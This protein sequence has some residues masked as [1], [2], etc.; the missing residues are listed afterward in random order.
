[1][2]VRKLTGIVSIIFA[3][4]LCASPAAGAF[5]SEGA[6]CCIQPGDINHD[7]R[8]NVSDLTYLVDFMF[9][10]GPEIPCVDEADLNLDD[11]INVS[12]LTGLVD[13]LF[14]GGPPPPA[15]PDV[16]S[17]IDLAPGDDIVSGVADVSSP[18]QYRVVLWARTNIWYIQP[19]TADPYTVIRSDGTWSN[20]TNPWERI[21]ALLVDSTYV[22]TP[23]REYH[24]ASDP[25]VVGWDEYPEK[26]P[27]RVIDWSGYSWRVKTGDLVGPGPNWFSD[28]TANVRVDPGDRLHLKLDY[29]DTRWYCAEIV[30]SQSLGY[31]RYTFR[32]D[33]RV[34]SLD[35]NTIFAGFIY[36][37]V[38]REFDLEFSQRLADPFN[39]QYVVQPWYTSGNIVFY[40]MPSD[41][42]TSHT[43]EWRPDRIVFESWR[44]HGDTATA[45][46]FIN[47]WTYTGADIPP[48][49][50]ER[51]RF[52]L[53]LYGGDAPVQGLGDEVVISSF[54]F[55]E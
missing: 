1:M 17:I 10:G 40:D 53:Y 45:A 47:E 25:G 11:A 44:G 21:V 19:T 26:A 46:T 39:A 12:D 7:Q 9:Q 8:I 33:T 13:Y 31:G 14:R 27:D 42:Q 18:D 48:P 41:S 2:F 43:F 52:N 35:Y 37:T 28:D 5:N 20:Y 3:V 38:D 50:N 54:D 23:T 30:L 34:D 4:I 16:I 24:P 51:M 49:G 15:C 6:L 55:A 36:E 29:R 32:L 22:P